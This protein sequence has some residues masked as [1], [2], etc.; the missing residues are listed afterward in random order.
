MF[1]KNLLFVSSGGFLKMD[2]D[3]FFRTVS[4]PDCYL[5]VCKDTIP[6]LLGLKMRSLK[7]EEDRVGY[8]TVIFAEFYPISHSAE[9]LK[10]H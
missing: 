1:Q 3:S 6:M 4:I 10:R 5:S 7:I 9:S 2:V 8:G